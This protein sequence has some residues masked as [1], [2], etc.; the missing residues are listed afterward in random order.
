METEKTES[1][2]NLISNIDNGNI[3]LPEFQRDFVWEVDKTFELFDSIVKDIFI[4]AVIYGKPSFEIAIRNI[5]ILSRKTRKS[6]PI[7]K[8]SKDDI[9]N[10]NLDGSFRVILDGQQRTTSIYRALKGIDDIWFI[11][12]NES[13]YPDYQQHILE[14]PFIERTIEEILY[15]FKGDEDKERLSIKLSDIYTIKSLSL[16][17]YKVKET[18]FLKQSYKGYDEQE[19]ELLFEN[20][21]ILIDKFDDFFKKEKL[22]SYY[23]LDMNIDKFTLFFERSNS[24]GIS[25]NFTD[26]LAAKLYAGDFN[27]REKIEEFEENNPSYKDYFNKE[28][29]T[30]TIAYIIGDGKDKIDKGYILKQLNAQHFK[31]YW[32]IVCKYYKESLHFLIDNFF[33][34]SQSWMPYE[35]MLI[36]LIIFRKEINRDF[37]TITQEQSLYIHYWYWA[38]IFSQRYTGASN[39]VIIKDANY[40]RLVAKNLK[41]TDR[42]FFNKLNKSL[43]LKE[44]DLYDFNRKGNAIY[45]GIL[46]LIHYHSKGLIGW[47]NTN[48]L[49][50]NDNKLEDHHIFPI[51][52]IKSKYKSD[53]EAI[54][55]AESVVNRTL[56][57]KISNIRISDKS[58]SKYLEELRL[59]NSDIE[60]S[61]INHSIP[62][63]IL[64][65]D[66]DDFYTIIL[67]ERAKLLYSLIE[68]YYLN[69]QD[70]VHR[71]WHKE[72]D[73]SKSGNIN[74]FANYYD[75]KFEAIYNPLT[76]KIH[77]QN[78]IYTPSGAAQK[79]KKDVRGKD[80]TANG[81]YFWKYINE[82][83]EEFFIKELRK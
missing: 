53:Y 2:K 3:V 58:P 65:T 69:K 37:S 38:S 18:Y 47:E 50:F 16:R 74:V 14:K 39:E 72:V 33:I 29:I 43:I 48:K 10:K 20:Y 46:N 19:K 27:L 7:Y 40:L 17:E 60:L 42:S 25:L 76:Q 31:E 8:L 36:P 26:I 11:A 4:G 78:E 75:N 61:L 9:A 45:Q 59:K 64:Q 13:D 63:E 51:N 23:L 77:F 54:S 52:Y 21:L 71:Q 62:K 81:W 32:D 68:K 41:I 79:I 73:I 49:N 34:V 28:L 55:K 15:E 70:E 83:G 66:F 30:R 1:I 67:E 80:A 44:K 22:L 12:K 6:M 56:I 57:P 35:S 5:D 24:K 82:N